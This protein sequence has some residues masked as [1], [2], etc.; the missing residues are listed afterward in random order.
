MFDRSNNFHTSTLFSGEAYELYSTLFSYGNGM[1]NRKASL[2]SIYLKIII[3]D[4]YDRNRDGFCKVCL[5]HC[6]DVTTKMMIQSRKLGS[7]TPLSSTVTSISP[8]LLN[9][10]NL[11]LNKKNV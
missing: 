5:R 3:L 8:C 2:D 7:T 4:V 6:W 10:C 11:S 9:W 1:G